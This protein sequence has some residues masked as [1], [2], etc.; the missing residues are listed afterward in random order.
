MKKI[1]VIILVFYMFILQSCT[2]HSKYDTNLSDYGSWK[3]STTKIISDNFTNSLP[4]NKSVNKY[5]HEYYYKAHQSTFG[6]ENF[7]IYVV[8]KFPD[9]TSYENELYKYNSLFSSFIFQ[10]NTSYYTIQYSHEAVSEYTNNKIHDGM[11]YN[12]EII[13]A[14][15]TEYT[16]CFINARVWDYYKDNVLIDFLNNIK[17]EDG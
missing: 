11:F 6:D 4:C 16:I 14:N 1:V 2:T 8:L 17:T 10:D 12:F 3:E 13:S 5:G 15:K 9:K 7:V